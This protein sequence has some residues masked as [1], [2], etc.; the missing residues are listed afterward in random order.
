LLRMRAQVEAMRALAYTAAAG[1]DLAHRLTDAD[2]RKAAQRRVDLLIPIVKG[3]STDVGVEAA[4]TNVQVHGGMGYIE[5]TGAAQHYRDARISAIY[6]G[7]NG[8]QAIDLVG[9]KL[10]R[11]GGEAMAALAAEIAATLEDLRRQ[12]DADLAA[13]I[14]PLADGLASLERT[15]TWMVGHL[16]QQ[17]GEALAGATSY[18]RLAGYVVGGWLMAKAA[19]A[20]VGRDDAFAVQKRQVARFFAEQLIPEGIAM[21]RPIT[22][23]GALVAA[24]GPDAF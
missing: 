3:W 4:S 14:E 2:A 20:T 1:L 21:E 13:L 10:G 11:D 9:R 22:T 18:L 15:T 23:G 8:I 12:D 19:L 24:M 6:E 5:E 7:T 17:P 16:G